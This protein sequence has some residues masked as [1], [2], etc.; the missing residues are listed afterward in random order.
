MY[1]V[2]FRARIDQLDEEYSVTAQRLRDRALAD[3]GCVAFVSASEGE[4]EI[5]LSYWRSLDDIQ[6]WKADLEH[7]SA[8]QQGRNRWYQGYSVEIA[9][10]LRGYDHRR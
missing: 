10:V 4:Q 8:Q 6:R 7:Q 2:I 3:F 5:A 9:E 1:V